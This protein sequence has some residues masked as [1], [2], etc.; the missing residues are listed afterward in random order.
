[1]P[2]NLSQNLAQCFINWRILATFLVHSRMMRTIRMTR[3]DF[4]FFPAFS[5]TLHPGK[6][7]FIKFCLFFCLFVFVQEK[8]NTVIFIEG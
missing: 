7:H 4:K 6:L 3:F 5:K 2:P 8:N 1:M